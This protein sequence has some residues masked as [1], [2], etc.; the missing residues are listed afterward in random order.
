[1]SELVERIEREYGQL[2]EA[3]TALRSESPA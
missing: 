1:V 3:L 2:E